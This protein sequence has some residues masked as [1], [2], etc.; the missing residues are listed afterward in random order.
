MNAFSDAMKYIIT[1]LAKS[2]PGALALLCE[3]YA[4]YG[5]MFVSRVQEAKLEGSEIWEF[6]KDQCGEDLA[7]MFD[8]L[9]VPA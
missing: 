9:A 2:D 7:Q 6:Y 1:D 8:R 5:A 4:N 3:G